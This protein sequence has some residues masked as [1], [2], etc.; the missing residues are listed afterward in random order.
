MHYYYHRHKCFHWRLDGITINSVII[1]NNRLCKEMVEQLYF[2]LFEIL[3]ILGRMA[4][5]RPTEEL[6][7]FSFGAD[8]KFAPS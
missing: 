8:L 7:L 4:Y 1:V 2:A 6:P 5:K 3:P